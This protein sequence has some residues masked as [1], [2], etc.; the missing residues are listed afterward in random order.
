MKEFVKMCK[1]EP[2]I[3]Y[4]ELVPIRKVFLKEAHNFT[5]WLEQHIDSLAE[6]LQIKL[7]DAQREKAAGEFSVDLLCEDGDGRPV[8]IENQLE[9]TN[10]DHLGKVLTYLVNL[11]AKTAI[12]ITTDPRPEHQ[13]VINWLNES[14]AEDISFYLVKVEGIRIGNSPYAPLFTV[15]AGPDRQAKEAGK[16]KKEW[17]ERHHLRF[18]FWKSLLERSRERTK[19]FSNISPGKEHWL[20]TGAGKSGI[21][22][23]YVILRDGGGVTLYIDH[24][25]E[26]GKKN[27]QIFDA[28]LMDKDA[29]EK[30]F[31][32]RIEWNRSDDTRASNIHV[33]LSGSGLKEKDTWPTLQDK[34]IDTMI[35]FAKAIRPRLAKI[36]VS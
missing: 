24:D 23:T 27:K 32:G 5:P 28:L 26:T 14:T 6:R 7:S 19:L 12:W 9:P 21:I 29:I 13:K 4:L 30:E 15:L 33:R 22:F 17:A 20:A 2:V 34:M 31:G 11:D 35:R 36:K 10:H 8:I 16:T 1:D 3:S 18:E 25:H